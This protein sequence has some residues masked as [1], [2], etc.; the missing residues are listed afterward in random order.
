MVYTGRR[1]DYRTLYCCRSGTCGRI[2]IEELGGLD[3]PTT[4]AYT[5]NVTDDSCSKGA[6]HVDVIM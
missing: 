3:D 5:L 4:I 2:C 6:Y 1:N